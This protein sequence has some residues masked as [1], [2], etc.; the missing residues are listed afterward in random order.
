MST[1]ARVPSPPANRPASKL[2][3]PAPTAAGSDRSIAVVYGLFPGALLLIGIG[4]PAYLSSLVF[5]NS[6][7]FLL[8]LVN[9]YAG[10]R[11]TMVLFNGRDQ[12]LQLFFWI[13]SWVFF[14]LAPFAQLSAGK[15]PWPGSIPE[16]TM[17]TVCSLILVSFVCYD[18]GVLTSWRTDTKPLRPARYVLSTARL[19]LAA[20][21]AIVICVIEIARV[22]VASLVNGRQ[23]RS[24]AIALGNA[25][26]V[27]NV[28]AAINT[29]LMVTTVFVVAY[30]F[31]RAKRLG[32]LS[33]GWL[34]LLLLVALTV[35]V[36]NPTSTARYRVAAVAS[37]L[38]LAVVWPLG[39]ARMMY[40][41]A[42]ILAGIAFLFPALNAFRRTGG[43]FSVRG[44]VVD[45]LRSGDYDAFQQIANTTLYVG[46]LGHTGGRQLLSSLLFFVPRSLWSGK[47]LDTGVLVATHQGYVF[48]NLSSPLQAEAYIDGGF[49][50]VVIVFLILGV[51]T[52]RF[53][54]RSRDALSQ[55]SFVSMLVPLVAAYQLIVLRGSLLQSMAGL[56]TLV[57]FTWLCTRRTADPGPELSTPP[58]V[59]NA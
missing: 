29:A 39:R 36:S 19:R 50:L 47:S 3:A 1:T 46:D 56:V 16:P 38:V 27:D 21:L 9:A 57:L 44:S 33:R 49:P 54:R 53:E 5:L 42:G 4:V 14:G 7:T 10:V 43:A 25:G 28:T 23:E 6:G 58:I 20:P 55:S 2:T 31:I 52:G 40:L 59:R 35:L 12:I 22:G 24:Q 51:V 18:L 45:S 41:G 37:G 34:W 15:W 30:L 32:M 8:L 13:F 26:A 17:V 11:M 48:T